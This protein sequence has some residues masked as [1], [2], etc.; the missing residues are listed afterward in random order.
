MTYDELERAALV[1]LAMRTAADP[2]ADPRHR[3]TARR[4]LTSHDLDEFNID[5][6]SDLEIDTWEL[7]IAK[8]RGVAVL[9]D[10]D[11][12]DAPVLKVVAAP[13]EPCAG[14]AARV[15]RHFIDVTNLSQRTRAEVASAILEVEH[16]ER[17][18]VPVEEPED[19][20]EESTTIAL[21]TVS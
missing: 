1:E 7:L 19:L 16:D 12:P 9:P 11:D 4:R 14:C 20:D 21:P 17:H 18:R 3:A 5:R 13:P 8:A 15:G 10:V 2:K 6:L